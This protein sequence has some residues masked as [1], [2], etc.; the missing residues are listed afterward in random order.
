MAT[1]GY[2]L[3]KKTSWAYKGDLTWSC[4]CHCDD[5]RRNCAAPVV[6]WLGVPI[7]NFEWTGD[8]PRTYESSKGVF[9]HFCG[10]CGSPIGFEADHYPGGMHLYAG[11]LENPEDFKPTFHVNKQSKLSWL[12]VNDNLDAFEGT[13]LHTPNDPDGYM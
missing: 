9:R 4:Y 6:A 10:T 8:K 7:R 1:R 2:C 5:C 13:L 12:H 3:C 11:S